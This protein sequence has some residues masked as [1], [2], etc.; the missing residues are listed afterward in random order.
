MSLTQITL[1]AVFF[2]STTQA[3][4]PLSDGPN[5]YD[6]PEVLREDSKEDYRLSGDVKPSN[7]VIDLTLSYLDGKDFS[8]SGSS[9]IDIEVK[10]ETD[11]I[12]LHAQ[13]LTIDSA[14]S[15]FNVET[16][17]TLISYDSHSIDDVTNFLK[18][19]FKQQIPKGSYKLKLTY[20]GIINDQLRGFHR[21]HY[22]D[23]FGVTR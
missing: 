21:G 2:T 1:F 20:K 14:V 23:D 5:F 12:V 9:T 19:K 10:N 6:A 22:T 11:T 13:N 4:P 3:I 18:I 8:F 7:Y 17:N 15:L 16:P